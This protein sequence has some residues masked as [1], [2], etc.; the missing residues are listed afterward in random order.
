MSK[1]EHTFWLELAAGKAVPQLV[2]GSRLARLVNELPKPSAQLPQLIFFMGRRQKNQ[3]LRQLCSSNYRGQSRHQ[4]SINIRSDNRT[5]HSLQPRF[6]ADCDPT[7]R[8]LL[9]AFGNL[10][11][12][13]PEQVF[14]VELPTE[15]SLLDLMLSRLLFLFVDVL[16]IF[17]DD[18]GGLEGVR[19]LL[20]TWARI[21][22]ASSLPRAVRPRVIVVVGNTPSITHS[23]LDEGDFLL[24]LLNVADLPFFA[25]FGDIKIS[26]LL[27][28]ELSPDARYLPLGGDITQELRN[29]RF[30][31][32]CHSALFT[33]R[34]FQAFFEVA[35]KQISTA[36]LSQ[37]DFIR[38][39]RQ[40]NP[41][42]GAF[43]SHLINFLKI[44]N[45]TRAPYD[46]M[47]SYI[48]SAILMDAYP[49]GMPEIFG[50]VA[51]HADCEYIV[52][53]CILC[54]GSRCLT[55]RLKP[56]TAAP[57]VLSIDGGGSR[58]IV[59]LE[60]LEMLQEAVGPDMPIADLFDL[61]VGCSSG[62]LLALSLDILRL[63]VSELYGRLRPDVEYEPFVWQVARA[64][65]AAPLYF[66]AVDIPGLGTFQDG[67]MGRHNNPLNIALSEA[68]HL[69]PNVAD[70]DVVVTLGTGSETASP[71][72][73]RF[74]NALVDGWIPRV[75]R[76]WKTSFNGHVTWKEVEMRLGKEDGYFRFDEF[77]PYGLPAMDSTDCMDLLS[78]QTRMQCGEDHEEAALALLT[79]CLYFQLNGPPD[80][81]TGLYHCTG[82][83]RCRA[84]AQALI[85]RLSLIPGARDFYKENLNLGLQLS[86][87]DICQFA[88]QVQKADFVGH[89]A[90]RLFLSVQII[91]LMEGQH[92]DP[93]IEQLFQDF[94][95]LPP[96][97][98]LYDI[99]VD[100]TFFTAGDPSYLTSFPSLPSLEEDSSSTPAGNGEIMH[101]EKE[102]Q[103]MRREIESLR[104]ECVL[105]AQ[106]RTFMF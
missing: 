102:H 53:Q 35:L 77:L 3:A 15:H 95:N 27:P 2:Y 80:Y 20:A 39:A 49:P 71:K 45:K 38:A 18:V 47:A 24:E 8:S 84:P 51:P 57:R 81:Q 62:G 4:G 89:G 86:S 56:P 104:N 32:E 94:D 58:V 48:A 73:S 82:T 43:S 66:S 11:V 75:Y 78:D 63:G 30:S 59:P 79:A 37:F 46:E 105:P 96:Q 28:E 33:A 34:H 54:E 87:D 67:G 69:W 98:S 17:A 19:E 93:E 22:S 91:R 99:S 50:E 72:A 10:R 61:M 55:V 1:C 9:A 68:K 23:L 16:C 36:P 21:G 65:S 13:H 106:S 6:F 44:G 70:P 101:C 41:L 29:M 103:E 90:I 14:P 52:R 7:C 92:L 5:L 26:R 97:S 76:S 60:N 64:T 42:D 88:R 85:R 83:I 25:A 100:P 74:R 12:C 40:Q 31:R